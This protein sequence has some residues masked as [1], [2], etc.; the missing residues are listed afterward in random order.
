[1]S[2]ARGPALL[3]P[4]HVIAVRDLARSAAFYRDCLG[5]DVR[6]MGDAGWRWFQRD[7]F[8]LFAGECPDAPSAAEIGDHGYIAYVEVDDVDAL[9]AEWRAR[10]VDCIKPLRDEPWGMREFGIRTVDG[11]RML[12][13][14]A[15]RDALNPLPAPPASPLPG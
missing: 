14:T 4:R 15:V 9:H 10:G 1:M 11:H 12:F 5:F 8:V 7:A 3:A 2:G 13:A 6:E